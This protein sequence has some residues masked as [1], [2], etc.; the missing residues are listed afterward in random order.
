MTKPDRFTLIASLYLIL[1]N[2]GKILLMRRKNTGFEDGNYG[3]PSGHLEDN[4]TLTQ[5]LA[6]EAKE[7]I[8]IEINTTDLQLVGVMHRKYEDI[9]LDFFFVA[10]NYSGTPTNCELEKCDD[11][12]WFPLNKLPTNTI[13][14]L[15]QAI[16]NYLK[17]ISYSEVGWS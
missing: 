11:V 6:R 10:K 9:R 16:E 2:E 12:T 14:Y 13:V 17:N 15:R 5:G 3:L 7:E 1:I 8:G 4:E